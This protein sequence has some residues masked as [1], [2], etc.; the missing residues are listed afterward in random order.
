MLPGRIPAVSRAEP[1][2]QRPGP[3]PVRDRARRRM[4][5]ASKVG[6]CLT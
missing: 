6:S 3:R 1:C 5:Q 2:A 4:R